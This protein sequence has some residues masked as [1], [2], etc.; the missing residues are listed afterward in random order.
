MQP[1]FIK[2]ENDMTQLI[3]TKDQNGLSTFVIPFADSGPDVNIKSTFQG[4]LTTGV[5][6]SLTVPNIDGKPLAAIFSYSIG[7]SV[8]VARNPETPITPPSGAFALTT[9]Q[10]NPPSRNV[11]SGDVLQFITSD[12]SAE[13]SVSFYEI[14]KGSATK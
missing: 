5:A 4:K 10:L 3:I 14:D 1:L 7:S 13:I 6:R 12:T 11:F 8:W 9:A 2:K